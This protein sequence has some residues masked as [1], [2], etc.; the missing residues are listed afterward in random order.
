MAQV[1]IVI[2]GRQYQLAC[3]DG[4]EDHLQALA[5]LVD[6]HV[7]DLVRQVGQIGEARLLVMA[8]LL[9]AD[10]THELRREVD[11]LR[12]DVDSH[13]TKVEDAIAESLDDVADRLEHVAAGLERP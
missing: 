2:N 4:Q 1:E 11:E 12:Q 10:E 13:L 5:K 8:A 9:I 6:G 3:E 7:K